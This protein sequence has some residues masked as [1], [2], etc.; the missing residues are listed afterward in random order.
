MFDDRCGLTIAVIEGR[1]T[2][3]RR[4]LGR[5]PRI[6]RHINKSLF[7]DGID[8]CA[9]YRDERGLCRLLDEDMKVILPQYSVGEEVA[10]AQPYSAIPAADN[11]K[12]EFGWGNKM[13]VKPALMPHR[14]RITGIRAER[15]H[16]ISDEDCY[17]E[18]IMARESKNTG[19]HVF[20]FDDINFFP[21]P[22]R[23]FGA[24]VKKAMGKKG[25]LGN[26]FVWVYTFELVK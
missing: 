3:T 17:K 18:G 20:T 5:E 15:I 24:L 16:D 26:P 12:G 1:K 21:S 11:L 10:V 6:A 19:L 13:Y 25:W 2:M 4:V 22:K 7:D 23:A 8:P 9:F 14:I